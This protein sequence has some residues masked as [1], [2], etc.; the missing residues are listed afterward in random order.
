MESLPDNSRV[1]LWISNQP[2]SGFPGVF[3]VTIGKP[4]RWH[5]EIIPA[6]KRLSRRLTGLPMIGRVDWRRNDRQDMFFMPTLYDLEQSNLFYATDR[7]RAKELRR[8]WV[9]WNGKDFVDMELV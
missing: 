3:C 1:I 8:R 5:E 7:A 4:P 2:I 9:I 6:M